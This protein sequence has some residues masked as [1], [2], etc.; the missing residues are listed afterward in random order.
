MSLLIKALEQAAKDRKGRSE[1]PGSA[2]SMG[3]SVV[4]PTI[5][6]QSQ[7]AFEPTL[8][9]PPEP[10]APP[11]EPAQQRKPMQTPRAASPT[12]AASSAPQSEAAKPRSVGS[13]SSLAAAQAQ[14]QRARAATVMQAGGG[15]ASEM[16]AILRANPVLMVGA[17]AVLVG[18]VFG[19]Y[20]YL[21]I[22]RPGLFTRQ[23]ATRPQQPAPA[24]APAAPAP[25]PAPAPT[26]MPEP[27]PAA[28]AAAPQP[29]PPL[30]GSTSSGMIGAPSPN[31]PVPGPA[32]AASAPVSTAAVVAAAPPV[33]APPA[34]APERPVRRDSGSVRQAE[35]ALAAASA[36]AAAQPAAAPAA[37]E[38][39]AVSPTTNQPRVNPLLGQ[40]YALLQAGDIEQARP[41]YNRVVQAEPLNIDALLGL[42]Y[43]AT[44]ENRTDDATRQYLRILQLNPRHAV[45]QA[46]L[47]GLMGRA[48]PAAAESR[49]KQ[50]IAREPSPFLHFVLGNLYADQQMWAQAQQSYF[51]AHHLEPDNPDY[52]YNL[53]VGL[54]HLRQ[55]KVALNFYRRAEQLATSHGRS[56]FDLAHARERIRSLTSQVE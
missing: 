48:D 31:V 3:R 37:R 29:A 39:I 38:R 47:I 30:P 51:Q 17:L 50:L 33:E 5:E 44:Q 7:T 14:E 49:L 28:V 42:A 27:A 12:P 46:A 16:F 26:T 13:L 2:T 55:S 36:P 52:A 4:E 24:S 15:R 23:V 6:P 11:R 18:L 41:L 25:A 32:P 20:V 21:Q 56:N 1:S 8:E 19:I 53:A 43:I 22:A 40:A 34:V 54:D 35:P 9:P 10:R 45:A